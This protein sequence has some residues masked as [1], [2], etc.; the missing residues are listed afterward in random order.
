MNKRQQE[1][2]VSTGIGLLQMIAEAYQPKP[3]QPSLFTQLKTKLKRKAA[4]NTETEFDFVNREHVSCMDLIL[5][6]PDET[7][8]CHDC[9]H[10][11]PNTYTTDAKKQIRFARCG[12]AVEVSVNY[13][14]ILR[15]CDVGTYNGCGQ[16]GLMFQPKYPSYSR[17][18]PQPYSWMQENNLPKTQNNA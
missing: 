15:T 3:A 18:P 9:I 7:K 12:A 14:R 6:Q 1:I 8:A 4:P 16:Q 2:L 11:Q 17:R 10:F 13:C 5:N